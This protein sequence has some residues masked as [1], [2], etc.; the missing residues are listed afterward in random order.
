MGNGIILNYGRLKMICERKKPLIFIYDLYP[1]FDLLVNEDN[2]KY[3]TWLKSHYRRDGI[4]E[5]FNRVDRTEKYKMLSHMYRY[6]SRLIE[7]L[8]DYFHPV[9]E[10]RDNGFSPLIGGFDFNKIRKDVDHQTKI[11]YNFDSLK[12]EYIERMIDELSGSKLYFVVSPIWYGM[13]T[14]QFAPVK[15]I[16][17]KHGITFIDFSNDPKYVHNNL[18][19]KDGIHL[20]AIGADEFTNDL[21]RNLYSS[22]DID[23]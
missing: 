6:N 12:I 4:E 16:C 8:A 18:Y 21:I 10:T 9:S 14:L 22:D 5:I 7:L 2:H 13:D 1:S 15:D 11:A 20:N 17:I 19:F 3:L 23:L